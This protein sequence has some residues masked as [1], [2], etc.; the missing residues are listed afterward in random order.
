MMQQDLAMCR[1]NQDVFKPGTSTVAVSTLGSAKEGPVW[2]GKAFLDNKA[3]LL[4][5][6]LKDPP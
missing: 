6:Q 1:L 2:L 3:H 4:T 5:P